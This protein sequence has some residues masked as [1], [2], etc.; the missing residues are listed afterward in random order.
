MRN[1]RLFALIITILFLFTGCGTIKSH[2]QADATLHI[3][4]ESSQYD[5]V[6]DIEGEAEMEVIN[7]IL[8]IPIV[9]G[10]TMKFGSIEY[11]GTKFKYRTTTT[12]M[13]IFNAI[14]AAEAKYPGGVD[15]IITPKATITT[16]GFPPFY[17]KTNVT[18]KGKG[19]R[20]KTSD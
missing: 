8:I 13:A 16:S 15:A 19:I 7:P 11:A 14:E 2:Y 3:N 6:G 1:K 17:T 12:N 18:V 10:N 5:I 4:V 9:I 20:F